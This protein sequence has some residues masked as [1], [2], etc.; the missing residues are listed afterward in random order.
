MT[1][2]NGTSPG[3][4]DTI[5]L[6]WWNQYLLGVYADEEDCNEDAADVRRAA[7]TI[8]GG[9]GGQ[10]IVT[11]ERLNPGSSRATRAR[12]ELVRNRA[13]ADLIETFGLVDP[14]KHLAD[15]DTRPVMVDLGVRRGY[16][17]FQFNQGGAFL[18]GVSI[19]VR[20]L[21]DAGWEDLSIAIWF[22]TPQGSVN[23]RVPAAVLPHDPMFVIEAAQSTSLG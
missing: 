22:S 16:A 9:R 23:G 15:T 8:E 1:S 2:D 21:R 6:L 20:A 10:T 13:V 19:A 17:G 14:T 11:R 3:R 18:P 7:S 5:W 4:S 12:Y